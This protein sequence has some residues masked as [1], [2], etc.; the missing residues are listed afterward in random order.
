VGAALQIAQSLRQVIR[1]LEIENEGGSVDGVVTVSIG[2]A[3]RIPQLPDNAE[4]IVAD[5]D[6]ALYTAK[7]SGKNRVEV[8][9]ELVQSLD[10]VE[11]NRHLRQ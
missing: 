7:R 5:A 2:V 8:A 11:C 10:S 9:P 1:E 4:S 6:L 3:S